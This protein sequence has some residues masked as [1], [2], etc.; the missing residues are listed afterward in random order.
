[1]D[2]TFTNT[3]AGTDVPSISGVADAIY[4]AAPRPSGQS[5]TSRPLI[6]LAVDGVSFSSAVR[7]WTCDEL[8]QLQ[9]TIPSTSV[10]AWL[11]AFTGAAVE[12][13]TAPGLVFYVKRAGRLVNVAET[14]AGNPWAVDLL[15]KLPTVFERLLADGVR[16]GIGLGALA[17]YPGPWRDSL[18]RGAEL[19]APRGTGA[20]PSDPHAAVASAINDVDDALARRAHPLEVIC[21]YVDLDSIVHR[22]GYD[23]DVLQALTALDSAAHRWSEHGATVLAVSDHGLT[24]T[25]PAPMASSAWDELAESG[26]CLRPSGG[27]GRMRWLYAAPGRTDEVMERASTLLG[28]LGDVYAVASVCESPI[29]R[30]RMGDVLTLARAPG[31]PLPAGHGEWEHGSTTP[32][33]MLIPFARWGDLGDGRR[34]SDLV[35]THASAELA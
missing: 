6:V 25:E 31:F 20:T 27:A 29:L 12:E 5:D 10:T 1:M 26:A 14:R 18:L 8:M 7:V 9:T 34:L 22:R 32:E 28:D 30:E 21:S 3:W 24:A 13:H 2:L 17:Q 4:Q 23:D 16:S 15:P 35:A 11:T 19:M 33:E